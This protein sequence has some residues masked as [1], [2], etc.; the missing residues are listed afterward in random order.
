MGG[1]PP[2]HGLLGCDEG[3]G[4]GEGLSMS[5]PPTSSMTPV[6]ADQDPSAPNSPSAAYTQGRVCFLVLVLIDPSAVYIYN[7]SIF[8]W[9]ALPARSRI[10]AIFSNVETG[11]LRRGMVK[12]PHVPITTDSPPPPPPP[13]IDSMS[14]G[15][16]PVDFSDPTM[17][18]GNTSTF[19]RR[20]PVHGE[21]QRQR[22][23][24]INMMRGSMFQLNTA[25]N[26]LD[27]ATSQMDNRYGY[28]SQQPMTPGPGRRAPVRLE[29]N[30]RFLL[31]EDSDGFVSLCKKVGFY[32]GWWAGACHQ[33]LLSII[34]VKEI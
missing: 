1:P 7:L 11:G 13:A 16:A 20:R 4:A 3:S 33:F 14:L 12:N 8:C 24:G 23:A 19:R 15:D 17:T 31:D 30:Y 10:D 34:M 5:P 2:P 29:Q 26:D 6:I 18:P 21:S 9:F 32:C 25:A 22:T 27:Y 28:G